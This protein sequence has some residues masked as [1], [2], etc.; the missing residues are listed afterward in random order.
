MAYKDF[1]AE[2][3]AFCLSM[4]K[5]G[6]TVSD[7]FLRNEKSKHYVSQ[8]GFLLAI[9]QAI[10]ILS[11]YIINKEKDFT[12]ELPD[13]GVELL[14]F[15]TLSLKKQELENVVSNFLKAPS[16][17]TAQKALQ[18]YDNLAEHSFAEILKDE[19]KQEINNIC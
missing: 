15:A 12:F 9:Q 6:E 2:D 7:T 8:I 11:V 5:V 14:K 16:L 18:A 13:S 19:A 4:E 3:R 1:T 17:D 10:E